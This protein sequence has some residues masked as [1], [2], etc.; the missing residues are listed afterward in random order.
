MEVEIR[1]DIVLHISFFC[2][3]KHPETIILYMCLNYLD[4]AENTL[5]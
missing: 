2:I 1:I 5:V 4:D 3:S